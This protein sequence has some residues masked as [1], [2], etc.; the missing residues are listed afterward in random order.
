[1]SVD[2]PDLGASF[3]VE[4][5]NEGN[6]YATHADGTTFTIRPGVYLLTNSS[7]T[8]A[9]KLPDRLPD[10][11]YYLGMR[12]FVCPEP[13]RAP[14]SVVLH[15]QSEYPADKPVSITATVAST[16]PPDSVSLQ[17][18]DGSAATKPV[19]MR[20]SAGYDYTASLPPGSLPS[21]E[22]RFT[23]SVS[24]GGKILVFPHDS[25]VVSTRAE[26][27]KAAVVPVDSAVVIFQPARDVPYLSVSRSGESRNRVSK[28]VEGSQPGT[29]AYPFGYPT[30]RMADDFT[31]CLYIGD[32]V[33]D[34]GARIAGAKSVHIT[35]KGVA[36]PSV[37]RLTL[38]ERDGSA[39]SEK[40]FASPQW[41][42]VV[43]P[44]ESLRSAKAAMIPQGYPGTWSY[45]LSPPAGRTSIDLAQV[46]RLQFSLR[47]SDFGTIASV[48]SS[49]AA[50]A[51][52]SVSL[53]Y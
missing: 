25:P 31:A 47:K 5:L 7:R 29:E 53:N 41:K 14:T 12:E 39:W 26:S 28:A 15:A 50:V 10:V 16:V 11:P 17:F 13:S 46:E 49:Q 21:G 36:A 9:V 35:L 42:E 38:V 8:E 27:Y 44:I 33:S 23:L 51:I 19:A 4:P 3:K 34:R 52:E 37:I 22:V 1:M 18:L 2:L 43:I 6:S 32:R 30:E 24:A 48:D 40:V 20:H 45:W